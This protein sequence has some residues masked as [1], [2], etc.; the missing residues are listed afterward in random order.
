MWTD[1]PLWSSGHS[2]WR[3]IQRSG[4]DFR[5]YQIFW[6]VLGLEWGPLSLVSTI[7]ELLERKSSGSGLE[8]REYGHRDLSSWPRG[9]L[10]P[11][12]LALTSLTSGGLWGGVRSSTQ[13]TEFFY[14]QHQLSILKTGIYDFHFC[15]LN[16]DSIIKVETGCYFHKYIVLFM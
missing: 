4:F 6:E 14:I 15:A 5:C 3:Q 10:Y 7:E 2:S 16:V 1:R 13:A 8:T 11:Q 12:N 9:I